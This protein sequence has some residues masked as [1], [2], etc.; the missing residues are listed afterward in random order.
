MEKVFVPFDMITEFVTE[1]LKGMVSQKK[2]PKSV[3]MY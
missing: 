1:H 2:M 3:L